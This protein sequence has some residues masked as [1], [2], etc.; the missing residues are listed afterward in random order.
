LL[1]PPPWAGAEPPARADAA[2]DP[3]PADAA[4]RIGSG[5]FRRA[6][7]GAVAMAPDGRVMAAMTPSGAVA[8]I[9]TATGKV[10]RQLQTNRAG[11]D[12]MIFTP[13]A[14]RLLILSYNGA[15]LW[16]V[17]SGQLERNVTVNAE[18]RF[19]GGRTAASL[20]ADG[21]LV[22]F[23]NDIPPNRNNATV[24]VV[25]LIKDQTVQT[26]SPLQNW[27]LRAVLSPD[28]KSLVTFGHYMASG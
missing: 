28:G 21:K 4:L 3:L 18:N 22:A 1:Q 8:L 9:D 26:I 24:V 12:W 6:E 5:R 11:M 2:G 14:K 15:A 20:S 27:N 19:R 13:D 10:A 7:Y 16:D 25:D 23:G 17:G